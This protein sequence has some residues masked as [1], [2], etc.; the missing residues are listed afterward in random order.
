MIDFRHFNSLDSLTSYFTS[1]EVC[2]DF[3]AEQRW[4]DDVVCPYCG[5]HHCHKCADGR[6][7]CSSRECGRK[8]GVTV[9]TIFES[10][11][12]ALRK[13]FM[14]IY[15]VSSHK[16]GISSC[17]I[18]RDIAV[19]QKTAW[20]M[21]MKIRSCF[22]QNDSVELKGDV[23]MDEA[24]VGGDN[25]WRHESKKI[26]G[27]QGGAN[28]TAIFGLVQRSNGN[29]V[30]LKVDNT[31]RKTIFPIIEQFVSVRDSILYTDESKIYAAL[32]EKNGYKHLACN[33]SE[34]RYSD[35]CGT[36]TNGIEGFWSHFKRMIDGIYH[37]VSED[38]IQCYIDEECFR[39]NTRKDDESERFKKFFGAII[40]T[41]TYN[42]V[43]RYSSMNTAA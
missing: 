36:H 28:K 25:K 31:Q 4:G 22:G 6:Y 7:H 21:L 19:T 11:H 24:Y 12:I 16:K 35:G 9:G 23:E 37:H 32:N 41:F 38:Y 33:H 14:A 18:S 10:S 26:A 30:A 8:F 5:A 17:Q 20:F 3:L 42:D 43:I 29:V 27:G 34:G 40:G 15:L 2:K 13:W 1:N 39:W